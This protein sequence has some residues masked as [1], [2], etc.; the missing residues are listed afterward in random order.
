MAI[1]AFRKSCGRGPWAYELHGH[2]GMSASSVYGCVRR[3][4]E[5]GLL[6]GSPRGTPRRPL[7]ASSAGEAV[8]ARLAGEDA[9]KRFAAIWRV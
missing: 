8:V 4:R 9:A 2:L 1:V 5:A 3:L 6:C 7:E